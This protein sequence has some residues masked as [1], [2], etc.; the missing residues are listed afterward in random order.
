MLNN[1]EIE[2]NHFGPNLGYN[3]FFFSRFQLY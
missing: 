1:I 2:K 3:F